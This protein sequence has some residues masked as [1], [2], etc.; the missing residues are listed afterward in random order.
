MVLRA[1]IRDLVATAKY[2]VPHGRSSTSSKTPRD[3]VATWLTK[4]HRRRATCPVRIPGPRACMAMCSHQVLL[5]LQGLAMPTRSTGLHILIIPHIPNLRTHPLRHNNNT[6]SLAT[7][8]LR[9]RGI[10]LT[11]LHTRTDTLMAMPTRPSTV[12]IHLIPPSIHQRRANI[13]LRCHHRRDRRTHTDISSLNIHIIINSVRHSIKD[14]T[15]LP[16]VPQV[17]QKEEGEEGP[18]NITTDHDEES[19]RMM[20]A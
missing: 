6:T 13:K 7:R 4:Q 14:I 20:N 16:Q 1:S 12:I 5:L 11:N 10:H 9:H 15:A 19:R 18:T 17:P 2:V 3:L 8:I